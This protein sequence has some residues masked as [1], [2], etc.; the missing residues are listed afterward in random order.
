MWN[1]RMIMMMPQYPLKVHNVP[2]LFRQASP[3]RVGSC[4]S[5]VGHTGFVEDILNMLSCGSGADDR[6][7]IYKEAFSMYAVEISQDGLSYRLRLGD[8]PWL[9]QERRRHKYAGS[10]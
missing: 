9:Y 5:T 4:F 3:E 10:C 7:D 2:D 8:L 6:R 1:M